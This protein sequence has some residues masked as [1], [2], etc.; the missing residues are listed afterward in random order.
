MDLPQALAFL[1][2]HLN[3]EATAFSTISAGDIEG[4]SLGSMVELMAFSGDAHLAYPVIHVTGTNGKGSVARMITELL[5]SSG[6][7]VGSYYSPHLERIN[8]RICR[9]NEP[10]G[11]DELAQAITEVARVT[12]LLTTPASWFELVTATALRW[13]A[14]IAVD[15]AVIEVG[16]L[17]R[18]DA[19][20]I[21]DAAVAVVTNVSGD[22][23]DYSD[24]WRQ[25]IA[26]EK[27][28]IIKE[29]CEVVI[30]P[31][32]EDLL[33]I[34]AE[35]L[36]ARITSFDTDIVVEDT[37]VAMGGR[38]A[39]ILTPYGRHEEVTIAAHGL[40]Q[41]DNAAMAITAVERLFDRGLAVEVVDDAMAR[42]RLP[43][44]CEV[45]LANP[46]VIVDG[47]HNA[48]A[49]VGLAETLTDD[50]TPLGS[51]VLVV[52]ML[53]GRRFADLLEPLS[54]V[55]FDAMI[56][57]TPPGERG[58]PASRLAAEAVAIGLA[59]T[60]VSNP[61]QAIG[62]ALDVAGDDDMVVIAGSFYQVAAARQAVAAHR[63]RASDD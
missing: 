62:R 17:G 63:R 35:Q 48:A 9:D 31:G 13:F 43:G 26:W 12:D 28:G 19:T 18:Y 36:P 30:G 57:T 16:L 23:T 55:G 25:K 1:D 34:F 6:L 11:D 37:Q 8:E 45:L 3:R 32:T 61:V 7:S 29:G 22:H 33:E 44:R 51:R 47:G 60:V 14:D 15:V 4:L 27:A 59:C 42:V 20:N 53:E 56:A 58:M 10:I 49:A 46:L 2:R 39:T 50:F 52:G 54:G 38:L 21:V 40:H 5:V 41:A 24:G